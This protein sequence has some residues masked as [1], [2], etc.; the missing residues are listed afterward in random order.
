MIGVAVDFGIHLR[1]ALA[2]NRTASRTRWVADMSVV[3][4]GI[5]LNGSLWGVGFAVLAISQ[6]PPNRYLGLLCSVV[7]G[8]ATALTLLMI[9]TAALALTR[10]REVS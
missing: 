6:I 7:V 10:S 5:L 1:S 3:T 2:R 9:P 8:V 4:R